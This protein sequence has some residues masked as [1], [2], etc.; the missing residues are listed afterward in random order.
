MLH[1]RMCN[2]HT[3]VC[4]DYSRCMS[5]ALIVED[6]VNGNLSHLRGD[7]VILLIKLYCWIAQHLRLLCRLHD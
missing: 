4:P 7:T 2:L 1:L 5:L 3:H 6:E